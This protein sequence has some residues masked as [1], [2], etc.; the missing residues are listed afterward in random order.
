M[1]LKKKQKNKRFRHT[2]EYGILRDNS[3]KIENDKRNRMSGSLDV[4]ELSSFL[5][6]D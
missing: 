6:I 2:Y 4:D 3:E 5:N 1:D